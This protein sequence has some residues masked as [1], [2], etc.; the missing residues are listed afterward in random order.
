MLEGA[1]EDLGITCIIG[2]VGTEGIGKGGDSILVP[3]Y[4]FVQTGVPVGVFET[5][6]PLSIRR[7]VLIQV[8]TK[9]LRVGGV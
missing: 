4:L 1:I 7:P 9:Y 8:S 6:F 5:F 3:S 2:H